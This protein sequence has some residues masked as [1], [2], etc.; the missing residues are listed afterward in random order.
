MNLPRV[1]GIHSSEMGM[2]I[3]T[4]RHLH[5]SQLLK[6]ATVFHGVFPPAAMTEDTQLLSELQELGDPDVDMRHMLLH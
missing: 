3:R 6:N 4:W 5:G 2:A 1:E